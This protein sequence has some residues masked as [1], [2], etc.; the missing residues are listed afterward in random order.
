M[1]GGD[2]NRVR[3]DHLNQAECLFYLNGVSTIHGQIGTSTGPINLV[4]RHKVERLKAIIIEAAVSVA[5]A[6]GG[7]AVVMVF[8][9]IRH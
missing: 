6:A 9:V 1:G 5:N 7:L 2:R 4:I 3:E 8:V